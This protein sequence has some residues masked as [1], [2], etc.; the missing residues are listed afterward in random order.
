MILLLPLQEFMSLTFVRGKL[1]ATAPCSIFY[2]DSLYVAWILH[3]V[4]PKLLSL[5]ICIELIVALASTIPWVSPPLSLISTLVL[6]VPSFDVT[7]GDYPT[8]SRNAST[9]VLPHSRSCDDSPLAWSF[10][11]CG[12]VLRYSASTYAVR[13]HDSPF[14]E[15]GLISPGYLSS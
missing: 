2:V 11:L 13:A 3:Q 7:M 8:C 9:K 1:H 10:K 5:S 4:P 12:V 15:L 14:G 6:S